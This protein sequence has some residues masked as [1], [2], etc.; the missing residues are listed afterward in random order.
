MVIRKTKE[1]KNVSKKIKWNKQDWIN[2]L[3]KCYNQ[4]YVELDHKD[5]LEIAELLEGE[6]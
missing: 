3:K 6:K 4:H 5:C 1:M 2:H